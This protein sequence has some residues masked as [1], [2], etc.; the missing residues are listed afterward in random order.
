M[1]TRITFTLDLTIHDAAQFRAAA[2]ARAAQDGVHEFDTSCLC[3][4]AQMLLDPGPGP[5][6]S[7]ILGSQAESTL[8][9]SLDDEEDQ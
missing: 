7:E 4:C 9:T 8:A 3:A 6:G 2:A 5:D 1:S